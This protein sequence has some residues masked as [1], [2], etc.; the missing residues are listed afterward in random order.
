MTVTATVDLF[1]KVA[2]GKPLTVTIPAGGAVPVAW[3][4][5]APDNQAAL[6]WQ[7]TARTAD[8]KATDKLTVSQDVIPAIP[9]EVWA[10]TLARVNAGTS[11]LIEPPAGAI[12]GRG[13]VEVGC[14]IRSR[15]RSR[16]CVDYMTAY[17]YNCFEQRLSRIVALGDVG[18]WT[19]LAGEIPTYQASDGLLRYFPQDSMSGS[20]ALTA[21]VLS[22]TA[23]AG[24]AGS[25]SGAREDGRGR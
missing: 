11:I 25:R 15:R 24:P 18:G 20:E 7:V 12:P 6:R 14:Q 19:R 2:Q 5:T 21:Y 17:P 3:N 1:P 16:A 22:L 23:E 9:V 10:A 8:G 13:T 4:L